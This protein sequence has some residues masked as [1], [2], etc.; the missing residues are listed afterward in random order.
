MIFTTW[1]DYRESWHFI[2]EGIDKYQLCAADTWILRSIEK[3]EANDFLQVLE[4]Q[5]LRYGLKSPDMDLYDIGFGDEIERI[6]GKGR[7]IKVSKYTVHCLCRITIYWENGNKSEYDGESYYIDFYNEIQKMT[8]LCIQKVELQD[9]N[10]L[11]IDLGQCKM[12][13]TTVRKRYESWRLF[14]PGSPKEHLVAGYHW[15]HYE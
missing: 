5:P 6:G 11:W 14:T 4:G 3:K 8:G 13:F 1:E 2:K 7:L 12:L 15:L 9:N 10:N